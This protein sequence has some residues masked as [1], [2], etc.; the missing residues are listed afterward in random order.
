MS[1]INFTVTEPLAKKINKVIK[2]WG[3]TSKAEFFRFIAINFIDK[4]E[5]RF[6]NEKEMYEYYGNKFEKAANKKFKNKKLPPLSEQ[7]KDLL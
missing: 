7:L 5:N 6:A 1:V 3:F 4:H 2:E